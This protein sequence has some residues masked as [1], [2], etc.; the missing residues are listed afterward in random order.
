MRHLPSCVKFT[1]SPRACVLPAGAR[2][3]SNH[4]H[5]FRADAL[6]WLRLDTYAWRFGRLA[7]PADTARTSCCS[8]TVVLRLRCDRCLVLRKIHNFLAAVQLIEYPSWWNGCEITVRVSPVLNLR[9]VGRCDVSF[10][11]WRASRL[12]AHAQP[13]E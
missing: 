2:S 11:A 3:L 1:K 7:L 4:A 5:D 10:N 8:C 6:D 12:P 9:Q 13:R